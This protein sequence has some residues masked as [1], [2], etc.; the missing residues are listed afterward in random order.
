[1]HEPFRIKLDIQ[2]FTPESIPID[3][4]GAYATAFSKLLAAKSDIAF[5][6]LESGS[7]GMV[8]KV[9]PHEIDLVSNNLASAKLGGSSNAAFNDLNELLRQDQTTAYILDHRGENIVQFPGI[10]TPTPP[11]YPNFR[12]DSSV[13]GQLVRI[14]GTDETVH[15]QLIYNGRKNKL[16]MDRET[17]KSI[18]PHL[19]G[20]TMRFHGSARYRRNPDG[21][22]ETLQFDVS[23]FEIL[24]EVSLIDEIQSIRSSGAFGLS[25]DKAFAAIH[26]ERDEDQIH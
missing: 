1:M 5:G 13:D 14:G 21:T 20:P 25:G 7:T 8:A 16:S 11:Q 26:A 2:K 22:W 23:S 24:K 19:F 17:A 15:A 12:E 6:G 4:L 9:P 3:R 10:N 18:A